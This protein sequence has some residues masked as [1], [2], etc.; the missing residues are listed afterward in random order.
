MQR[1]SFAWTNPASAVA[2]NIDLGFVPSEVWITNLTDGVLYYWND[3]FTDAYVMTV[4][5]GSIATSNG[6]TPLDQDA[7][8]GSAISGFTNA[9]PGVVTVA[10]GTIFTAG[11][12]VNAMGIA[13]DQS[14]SSSLNGQFTVASVS[15][16]SVTLS[17]NTTSYSVYVSG[18][19]LVP[20]SDSAGDPIPTQNYSIQGVLLGTSAVGGNNDSMALVAYGP[21]PV[22]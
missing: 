13:D 1:K 20:V 8:Y 5:S 19:L 15:G 17:E 21:D 18:G 3:N 9:N 10:D 14:Q 22:C 16:N 12:T 2:K 11:D 6:V 4:S 7:Q